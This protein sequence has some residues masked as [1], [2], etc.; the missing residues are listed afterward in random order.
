MQEMLISSKWIKI[1][2]W[3]KKHSQRP[4]ESLFWT[5]D[6]SPVQNTLNSDFQKLVGYIT[7]R[8]YLPSFLCSFCKHLY[9]QML[10]NKYKASWKLHLIWCNNSLFGLLFTVAWHRCT[11]AF[12]ELH[13]YHICAPYFFSVV[14]STQFHPSY[15]SCFSC[16]SLQD[17]CK[18]AVERLHHRNQSCLDLFFFCFLVFTSLSGGSKQSKV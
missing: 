9:W 14:C 11:S 3:R 13:S 8:I 1:N 15:F 17:A 10:E 6:Y 16:T 18:S 2:S 7:R 5:G 4:T 12:S